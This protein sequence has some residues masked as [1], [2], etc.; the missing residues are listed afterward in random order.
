[1]VSTMVQPEEEVKESK[2]QA[3]LPPVSS[4]EQKRGQER[5]LEGVAVAPGI[6]IGPVYH[7]AR[8]SF[9]DVEHREINEDQVEEE[10]RRFEKAVLRS[11]RDL[12]KIASIAREKIGE[13]SAEIFEAQLLMLRDQSVYE[14]VVDYVQN[15]HTGADYAVQKTMTKHRRHM[16]AAE[17]KYLQERA[18]DLL[19]VQERV[20]RHL[21]RGKAVWKVDPNTIVVAEDLNAT[22]MLLF[23]RRH[24]LGCAMD[25]GG[26]TSH[27]SIMARSLGVP[28]VVGMHRVTKEV[29]QGQTIILDGVTGRVIINP[30]P[31]TLEK[32]RM[33][34][35]RYRELQEKRKELVPLPSETLDGHHVALRANLEFE[36]E[37]A[38]LDEYGADGIGLFRTE[39]PFLMQRRISFD[40]SEQFDAYRR[41]VQA[42][43]PA[44]TTFRVIDV[45]GDKM[46]PMARREHNPMLG[47]RGLR[48]LLDK[49][50]LLK[51]QLRAILSA[52]AEGPIRLLLPM[53]TNLE[54]IQQFRAVLQEVQ[55]SLESEQ[56]HNLHQPE[57][58]IMV[59]VP[60]VA[61]MADRFAQEVDFF[62]IGSN[63]LTQYV[64]AVDRGNDLVGDRYDELHP[65]V[66]ILI[67]KVVRAGRRHGIP[68]SICGQMA[69]NPRATPILVGLQLSE[70][71][72]SPTYLPDLKRV[73]RAINY[74]DARQLAKEVL[75]AQ[76]VQQVHTLLD[77]WLHQ[78]IA[79][80][81][82]FLEQQ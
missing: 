16:E 32:Y 57:V 68:V 48:I 18:N 28:T 23:S 46:L 24:L 31:A 25:Y 11:E 63:D 43:S 41:I 1:M 60:S 59:E 82:V 5:V 20:I 6:A 65:A 47:W 56:V 39:I 64:L 34:Q 70:F 12:N 45:G 74:S 75:Q 54:E 72:A 42:V 81:E 27:V 50:E 37:L 73:L 55:L 44:V 19:D 49:P 66:L 33:R 30:Q 13:Q 15:R 7:Y 78:H 2:R 80:E 79:F 4:E 76:S 35:E 10:L 9:D 26:A 38:L 51:T 62:S 40:E 69:G 22:D 29:E 17:S 61:L 58:G 67:D 21:R 3:D 14:T 52:S 77:D 53:V 71:S 36:E 8:D